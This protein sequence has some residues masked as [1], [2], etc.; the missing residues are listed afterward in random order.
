M[1]IPTKLSILDYLTH[2]E[3]RAVAALF[4]M[5]AFLFSQWVVRIPDIKELL[6]LTDAS[7]GFA[8]LA[9]PLGVVIITPLVSVGI[10]K[11]GPGK[12]SILGGITYAFTIIAIGF[13]NSYTALVATLFIL[14][15]AN[16]MMDISMNAVVSALEKIKSSIFMSTTH[17]F[18]S[19]SAM[20][21]SL[22]ASYIVSTQIGIKQHLLVSGISSLLFLVFALSIHNIKDTTESQK[23][24]KLPDGSVLVLVIIAFVVFLT[25]GGIMDWNAVFY[26]DV[27]DSPEYLW[28]FGFASFSFTM[29]IARFYGDNLIEKY[30]TR[31]LIL[32]GCLILAGGLLLYSLGISIVICSI[33]M[34]ISGLGCSILIPVLFRQAGLLEEV[35]PSVGIATVSTL[36]YT[37]FLVG[38]PL[39]GFLSDSFSL[40]MSFGLLAIVIASAGILSLKL[41]I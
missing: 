9:S 31:Y 26:K 16:G 27:L 3:T 2:K 5:N 8:L 36:G 30:S 15:I 29:A 18:W 13:V 1:A 41:K 39:I 7:L 37:G 35:P 17:G 6:G 4:M 21:F 38:P 14:G 22:V 10:R 32:Y 25:E 40:E 33:A 23:S 24:F 11:L 28:G 20:I 12:I 34:M 19:L